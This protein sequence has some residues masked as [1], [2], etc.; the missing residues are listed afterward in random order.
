[1]SKTTRD[2]AMFAAGAALT[3]PR[4]VHHRTEVHVH[5]APTDESVNLLKDMEEKAREKAI[6]T[7]PL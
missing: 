5:R 3:R 4:D 1:M 7:I 6:A 2:L